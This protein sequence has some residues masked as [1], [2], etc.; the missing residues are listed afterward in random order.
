MAAKQPRYAV[1]LKAG[2]EYGSFQAGDENVEL[3]A[4][5]PR[6]ETDERLEYVRARDLPFVKDLGEVKPSAKGGDD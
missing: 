6:W 4:D 5:K 3:T 1:E 2:E